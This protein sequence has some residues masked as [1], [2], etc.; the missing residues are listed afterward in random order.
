MFVL[1][2]SK[3]SGVCLAAEVDGELAGYLVC[4]RYDLVWHIMN[5]SVDPDRRRRGIAT[6]LLHALFERVGDPEAQF[7]LEVRRSNARRDPRSTSASASRAP[8]IRRRYY[9]GQ[10]RGRDRHV[11]HPGDP[12]RRARRRAQRR[13]PLRDPRDRDLL[14]RHLRGRRH[15]RRRDPLERRLLARAS[16]TATAASCP[17][18]P[19]RHHLE[20]VNAVVDD[21]LARA[22]ATLDDVELVA[23]TQGPGLVGALLVGVATAKGLA[24]ARGLPL[25][26]VDH[27]Q[28]HVA[29]NFLAPDPIEPPFLCLIASGGHTLLARVT[30]HDALRAARHDARRRRRRGVRQGRAAARPRLPGRPGALASSPRD[31]DP[32]AFAFPT[33]ARVAGPGL[34]LR[35]P[36]DR[37]ALQGPR[38]GGGGGRAP[39]AP[40]SPPPTSTRSSRR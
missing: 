38:A 21:A 15:P 14:R 2:L 29:A 8:G 31:G 9:A 35:R 39:R 16:T 28:G 11:A 24:A 30:E 13:R 26:P 20:L 12:A 18:S 7:T 33:A 36:E 4:S 6:A 10:R 19:R 22:G 40:T 23:V 34:L 25:A 17:R 37:A 3:P 1:E 5:V 32:R 27:L